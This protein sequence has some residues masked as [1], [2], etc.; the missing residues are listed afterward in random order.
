[1]WECQACNYLNEDLDEQC[2]RCA[3]ARIGGGQQ[4]A[5]V[6]VAAQPAPAPVPPR[7][8]PQPPAGA[9]PQP[10]GRKRRMGTMEWL[11][12][13]VIIVGLCVLG[14]ALYYAWWLGKLDP[15]ILW[16]Y[17]QLGITPPGYENTGAPAQPATTEIPPSDPLQLVMQANVR[18]IKPL[19]AEAERLAA[20]R[21]EIAALQEKMTTALAGGFATSGAAP[22]EAQSTTAAVLD[23]VS[24]F[25]EQ[26][27]QKLSSFQKLAASTTKPELADSLTI[28]RDE[29]EA[30]LGQL[31]DVI[32]A[33]YAADSGDSNTAYLLPE[34]ISAAFAAVSP[35]GAER[36][37][38]RWG[39]AVHARE[40]AK[41]DVQLADVYL[42]L[43]A[44]L[45]AI[46]EVRRQFNDA[47]GSLPEYHIRAGL[48]PTAAGQYLDLLDKLES[49]IEEL[50]V[51][52]EEYRATLDPQLTSDKLEQYFKSYEEKA[53]GEH[54]Y[55]F[56]EIYRI[57][58]QD[59][60]LS[61]PAYAKLAAHVDFVKQHW[62]RI[63]DSYR[64]VYEKYEQEWKVRWVK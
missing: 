39:N 21:A 7:P 38:Q 51:E 10:A 55:A 59:K 16:A 13:A 53:Q 47:A 28:L 40:Q 18:G 22:S 50:Q 24:G 12:V 64:M 35:E 36:L 29:W 15:A 25:T 2:Q 19:R 58:A 27:F 62:P 3:A 41:L 45:D 14:G 4:D 30:Q 42:Q 61:H 37:R 54:M 9:Q 6:K 5:T 49:S 56:Q 34:R 11:S 52:Y 63:A 20:Q 33:A 8:A 60:D 31:I 43:Q 17:D 57:Y 23:E 44:R 1:M 48:L 26:L 32:G 46:D